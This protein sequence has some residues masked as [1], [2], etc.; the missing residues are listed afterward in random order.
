MD[1]S[2]FTQISTSSWTNAALTGQALVFEKQVSN[3]VLAD[4][5]TMQL[6]NDAIIGVMLLG[7][8]QNR[9]WIWTTHFQYQIKMIYRWWLDLQ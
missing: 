3:Q 7:L 5:L 1:C 8:S 2:H 4:K 6:Q 9:G